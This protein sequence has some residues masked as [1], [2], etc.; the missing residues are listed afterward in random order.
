MPTSN[1]ERPREHCGQ[2]LNAL[3]RFY[4]YGIHGFATEVVFCAIWYLI[5][6][7]NIKLHG[8]SS[9]WSFPI[10]GLSM[11]IMEQFSAYLQERKIPFLV[12]GPIYVLWTYFWELVCGLVLS[13][14]NAV[15]WDY[16]DYATY[17]LWGLINFEYAPLWLFGSFLCERIL[18]RKTLQLR[19]S[20]DCE[21]IKVN[22][23]KRDWL[24]DCFAW[25][26]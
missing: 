19:W 10:Y 2:G 6:D 20:C 9:I 26:F 21:A 25:L 11:L 13:S 15:S 1:C 12:R 24:S 7:K 17:H 5:T 3:T 22:F 14:F 8:F 23:V 16:T 4:I 18:M